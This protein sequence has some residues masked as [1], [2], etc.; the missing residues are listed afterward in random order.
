MLYLPLTKQARTRRLLSHWRGIVAKIGS[1]EPD[2][3]KLSDSDLRKKSL[4][5]RYQV[6]SGGTLDHVL[7]DAYSL[8]RE[9]ARRFIGMRHYD[10]QMLGGV[11]LHYGSVAEMQTGEG[12]TLTATL[13]LYLASLC[14]RGSHLATANDYLASRDAELVSPVFQ[15]LGFS[16]GTLQSQTPRQQRIAAYACDVTYGTSK[17]FGFDFLRDRLLLRN[18]RDE[19]EM[20]TV[21]SMLEGEKTFQSNR[22]VQRELNFALVDEADAILI[23]EARTPLIV[24]SLPGESEAAANSLYQWAAE[25][26]F[27]FD[28]SFH[29]EFD[30]QRRLASLTAEGRR[31]VRRLPHPTEISHVSLLDIYLQVERAILVEFQYT[32]DRQYVVRDGEIVI[33]DEFTGRLAEGRKWRNGIHQAIEA[34]EKLEIGVDTGQAAKIS[35]QNFF[36]LYDRLAGMT[37]T[38]AHSAHELK[39]I[40]ELNVVAIPTNKPPRRKKW[41]DKVFGNNSQK[42]DAIVEEISN[43][44]EQGRP[45]LVGTRSIDKSE[46]LSKLLMDRGIPHQLLNANNVT[47]EAEIVGQAGQRGKVTVATNMAGRGTDIQLGD[48][49]EELGGIH[50]ICSE[51]H[52]SARIDRQLI[53]RCGRQGDPGTFRQFL[54]LDDDIILAGH[55]DTFAKRFADK[56]RQGQTVDHLASQLRQAQRRVEVRHFKDRRTLMNQEEQRHNLQLQMGQDPFL[57]APA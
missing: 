7:P 27:E 11:A 52:E 43:V 31:L 24:S 56:G 37:G 28:E 15:G 33:V 1:L 46:L 4:S 49:V 29:F 50:V 54:S 44:H 48:E 51:L 42:W 57:D 16:V 5:L 23:D 25:I 40:Y 47:R 38:T 3:K 34:K 41:A 32:R 55:G 9:S 8:V 2:L 12:K 45:V 19:N 53:G 39:K 26:A 36:L 22:P 6:L 30:P 21:S 13:P 14:D 20:T 10:V 18:I 35:I 17:E